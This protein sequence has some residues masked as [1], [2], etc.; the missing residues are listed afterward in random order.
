KNGGTLSAMTFVDIDNDGDFDA[1]SGEQGG[2][3]KYYENTGTNS[4]PTFVEQTGANNPFDGIDIGNKSKPTFVDIDNDGDFDA[5]IGGYT[6]TF[7][8]YENTGTN[9]TA[10]FV[11]Q[12]GTNNPLGGKDA[13]SSSAP[14]F[15][16]IDNDGDFDMLSGEFGGFFKYYENTGTIS[17]PTFVEQTGA[18]NPLDGKDAGT[19]ST[20]T[21]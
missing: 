18:N 16:D 10:T 8:Y 19:H 14:T 4:S 21:F 5:F 3:I 15:V 9:S 13:G 1:F 7:K 2:T 6:G 12:T 11:E 17:S 20:P